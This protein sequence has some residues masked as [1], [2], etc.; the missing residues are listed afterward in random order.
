MSS[1]YSQPVD[2]SQ[3]SVYDLYA[4]GLRMVDDFEPDDAVSKY[5][6]LHPDADEAAVRKELQDAISRQDG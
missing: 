1:P 5:M 6:K 2:R 3:Y 4:T